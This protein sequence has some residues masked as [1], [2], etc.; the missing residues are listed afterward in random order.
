M[1]NFYN[2]TH[3]TGKVQ[4]MDELLFLELEKQAK[5]GFSGV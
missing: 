1:R 5:S 3:F 2:K 4:D